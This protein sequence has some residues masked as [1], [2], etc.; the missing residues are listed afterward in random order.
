MQLKQAGRGASAAEARLKIEQKKRGRLEK[1]LDMAQGEQADV[2]KEMKAMRAEVEM[3]QQEIMLL[4][5]GLTY[6]LC[7]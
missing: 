2:G 5:Q 1:K 6:E 4:A 3:H 7:P